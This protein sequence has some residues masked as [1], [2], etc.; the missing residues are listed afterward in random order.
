VVCTLDLD[1]AALAERIHAALE[2]NESCAGLLMRVNRP[3]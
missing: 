2:A 1:Y 3:A